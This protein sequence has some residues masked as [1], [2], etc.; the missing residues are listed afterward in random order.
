MCYLLIYLSIP[1]K[2]SMALC[3]ENQGLII[4]IA[5]SYSK[6]KNKHVAVSYHKL[7]DSAASRTV[8]SIMVCTTVN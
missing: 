2:V 7:R 6:L 8:N 1:V 4:S 3:E 5:N